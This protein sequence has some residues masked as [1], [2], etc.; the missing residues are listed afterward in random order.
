M[1]CLYVIGKKENY[2]SLTYQERAVET[3][4]IQTPITSADDEQT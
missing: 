2:V 1:K 4:L 3:H